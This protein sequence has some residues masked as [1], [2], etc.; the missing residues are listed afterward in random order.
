MNCVLIFLLCLVLA[1]LRD[2][3]V[4]LFVDLCSLHLFIVAFAVARVLALV[5]DLLLLLVLLCY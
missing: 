5:V 3:L 4:W 1:V 2:F